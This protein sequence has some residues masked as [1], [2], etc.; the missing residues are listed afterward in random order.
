MSEVIKV[1]GHHHI[2]NEHNK[3][4]EEKLTKELTEIFNAVLIEGSE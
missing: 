1:P 4:G 3:Y 2:I